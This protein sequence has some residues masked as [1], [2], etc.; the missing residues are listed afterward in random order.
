MTDIA[1]TYIVTGGCGFIGSNLVATLQRE[2]PGCHVVII[3][4]I[5]TGSHALVIEACTRIAGEPFRGEVLPD[6]VDDIDWPGL[7]VER[8]PAA[9]FHLGAITD[10]TVDDEAAMIRENAGDA[11]R[12]LLEIAAE[13]EI[14]LVYASSAATYG[15][16]SEVAD[17]QPFRETSAGSP[18]NVYGFSKWIMEQAHR[19]VA[20]ERVAEGQADPGIIG[21]RYFNVFGPGEAAKGHMSSMAYQLA[22][23]VIAGDRPRLFTDGTQTRDQVPVEDIVGLTLAAAGI[24]G[25]PDPIPG[26]YNAGSGRPTSFEQIAQAVRKGLGLSDAERPTEYFPMPDHIAAFYQSF[27]LADMSEAERALGYQPRHEPAEAIARYAAWLA[28]ER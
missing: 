7:I 14:P 1:P 5:R 13:A 23:Q 19:R 3:D 21:L 25:R 4:P 11:W 24:G 16:P 8:R 27:T 17:Q 15:T 10:T 18:N 9:I 6:S 28:E 12:L 22:R 2:R 26:V 20:A